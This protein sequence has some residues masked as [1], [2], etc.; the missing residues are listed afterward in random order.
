MSFIRLEKTISAQISE[1]INDVT[2]GVQAVVYQKG[3]KVLDIEVGETYPYYDLASLTKVIF[4]VP[5]MMLAFDKGLW[6]LKSKVSDF[7]PWFLHKEVLVKDVLSHSAGLV[8]WLPLY[9]KI[10]IAEETLTKWY[11][12]AELIRD[13]GL[14]NKGKSVYSDV[15]FWVL[16][17]VLEGLYQK[18]VQQIW[19]TTKD[20]LYAKST[21][22]F[23]KDNK[24]VYKSSQYAPTEQCKWRGKLLQGE[25]HDDNCWALDGVC[26]HAGLFGSL[27]DLGWY[28]LFLRSHV[29]S[30][31]KLQIKSNTVKLF[32]SRAIDKNIGDWG[33]GFMKPT[34]GS[35]SCGKYFS[36]NSFGHTGF[37]G[38]SIWFDPSS[39]LLICVLSNRVLY[40]RDN[41][42]FANL[43]PA[44]HN[45]IVEGL[46]R[47]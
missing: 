24:P 41:K 5:A 14:E 23:H 45:W 29:M 9:Q 16:G 7:V 19:E 4:T 11:Q 25:V 27:D 33:L 30:S 20:I 44:I 8:W 46:K 10:P 42:S 36:A 2:P 22:N 43:R 3:K 38:T 13:C 6:N 47:A 21:L 17:F 34:V 39:D 37:T 15:D 31:S 12:A 1:A 35:A 28:G 40:G 26:T 18:P 32:T